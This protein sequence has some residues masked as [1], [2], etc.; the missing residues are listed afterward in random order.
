METCVEIEVYDIALFKVYF[1]LK[2]SNL[3]RRRR[4]AHVNEKYTRKATTLLGVKI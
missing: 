2:N 3:R 4:K 1:F